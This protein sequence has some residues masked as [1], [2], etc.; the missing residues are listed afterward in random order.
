[1]TLNSWNI[2][3]DEER[4]ADCDQCGE[5]FQGDAAIRLHLRETERDDRALMICHACLCAEATRFSAHPDDG[6]GE[7]PKQT[8]GPRTRMSSEEERR[9]RL[10]RKFDHKAK[11]ARKHSQSTIEKN[12]Y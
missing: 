12:D 6:F 3:S 1:M 11:L 5:R 9:R 10:K 7:P 4:Y 8:V 2:P